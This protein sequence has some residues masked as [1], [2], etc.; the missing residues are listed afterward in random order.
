MSGRTEVRAV[1]TFAIDVDAG[2]AWSEG[3]TVAQVRSQAIDGALAKLNR[4]IGAEKG[5]RVAG[6]PEVKVVTFDTQ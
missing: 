1:V 2:S 4:A 6:P 3:T 5:I